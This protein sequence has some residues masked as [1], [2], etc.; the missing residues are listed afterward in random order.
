M[1]D[2]ITAF[3]LL[4]LFFFCAFFGWLFWK[5]VN[6]RWRKLEEKERAAHP[7]FFDREANLRILNKRE[8]QF[9]IQEREIKKEIAA[10]REKEFY[11]PRATKHEFE[12]EIDK[13][14][15]KLRD[16]EIK[17]KKI[18]TTINS[19]RKWLNDYRK[20]WNLRT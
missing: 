6:Y 12:I 11:A 7:D 9:F 3:I 10:L 17:R 8:N 16:L 2:L 18:E 13:L 5:I 4:V 15:W 14:C 20:D 1:G 19:E